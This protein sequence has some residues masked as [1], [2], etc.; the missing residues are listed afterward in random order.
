MASE[1][2]SLLKSPITRNVHPPG[3]DRLNAAVVIASLLISLA[4]IATAIGLHF[5]QVAPKVKDE[6]AATSNVALAK[7]H[8]SMI[9]LVE[10]V[11][12]IEDIPIPTYEP[13]TIT[14][15]P[16]SDGADGPPGPSGAPG[17]QGPQGARGPKGKTIPATYVDTV[18]IFDWSYRSG[19]G[20]Y[21]LGEL[22]GSF[23]RGGI[24]IFANWGGFV[25]PSTSEERNIHRSAY[26]VIYIEQL[27]QPEY[28]NLEIDVE[29][30]G[31][32]L[33]KDGTVT[34]ASEILTIT[35]IAGRAYA[36]RYRY[37]SLDSVELF[38]DFGAE[39]GQFKITSV[40]HRSMVGSTTATIRAYTLSC[41]KG[42]LGAEIGF[43][44]RKIRIDP[45]TRLIEDEYIE[46]IG[47][48]TSPSKLIDGVRTGDYDRSRL[49]ATSDL[50]CNH[51][52]D[53]AHYWEDINGTAINVIKGQEGEGFVMQF[54][55]ITGDEINEEPSIA[56]SAFDECR[57]A[58]VMRRSVDAPYEFWDD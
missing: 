32:R 47:F 50:E 21:Q 56:S 12:A 43:A 55:G 29:F 52:A 26:I 46:R 33:L 8:S 23:Y 35:T 53:L 13:I 27:N 48:D 38:H 34:P 15:R 41:S 18:T 4:A 57:V 51:Y 54:T 36:T 5:G 16:G 2:A 22:S 44:I 11:N 1:D 31:T 58:L 37:T 10:K 39:S 6:I 42:S 49:D 7:L 9:D 3:Q 19:I 30:I 14:G 25:G 40:M 20:S 28:E 17:P 24:Q 45:E